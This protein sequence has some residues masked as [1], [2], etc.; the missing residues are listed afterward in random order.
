MKDTIQWDLVPGEISPK[1]EDMFIRL[2][3]THDVFVVGSGER[4]REAVEYATELMV[5]ATKSQTVSV[6]DGLNGT[7]VSLKD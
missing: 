6:R 2:F 5:S 3:R 7:T 1:V 4:R